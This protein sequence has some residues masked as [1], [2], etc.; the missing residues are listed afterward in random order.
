MRSQLVE[1]GGEIVNEGGGEEREIETKR[2]REK[3][4]EFHPSG[5]SALRRRVKSK[6]AERS[7]DE[8]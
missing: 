5:E 6:A 1:V 3:W 4:R 2:E 7:D 8:D